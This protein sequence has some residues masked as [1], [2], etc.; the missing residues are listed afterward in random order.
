MIASSGEAEE[1]VR[2]SASPPVPQDPPLGPLRTGEKHSTD[3]FL[4]GCERAADGLSE[5][6]ATKRVTAGGCVRA[7]RAHW[8]HCTCC[9]TNGA[10]C[11]AWLTDCQL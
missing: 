5:A 9:G 6:L 3:P 11:P 1:G 10:D 7:H 8:Y 2:C 4:G